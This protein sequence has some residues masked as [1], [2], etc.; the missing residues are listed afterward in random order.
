MLVMHAR[1]KSPAAGGGGGEE[2]AK[3]G[4]KEKKR[5]LGGGKEEASGIFTPFLPPF[6]LC[7]QS[8]ASSSLGGWLVGDREEGQGYT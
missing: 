4:G 3:K 8:R 7:L 2:V 5:C 1:K 6:F